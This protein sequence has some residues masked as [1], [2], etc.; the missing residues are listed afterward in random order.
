[1][2]HAQH[3]MD[4]GTEL[5]VAVA[6]ETNME[7]ARHGVKLAAIERIMKSGDN[8]FTSKP[9]SFSSAEA[10]VATD[11]LYAQHLADLAQAQYNRIVARARYDAALADARL[12]AEI[13]T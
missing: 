13:N 10:V 1:M 9:H 8:P 11:P 12:A 3:I 6:S 7:N 4:C 2:D 5:A